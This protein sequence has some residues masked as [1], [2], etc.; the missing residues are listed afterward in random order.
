L[1]KFL[2]PELVRL[3][4]SDGC[5]LLIKKRLTAGE[6]RA[7]FALMVKSMKMGE[8][9]EIDP[10]KVQ[11]ATV[12]AYLVDWNL[13]DAEGKPVVIKGAPSSVVMNALDNLD[14]DGYTEIER[15]I[16]EHVVA[17]EEEKK[18]PA[19]ENASPATSDSVG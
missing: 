17:L 1:P 19:P 13:S 7:M 14:V 15:A 2:K 16:S 11:L 8:A 10:V 9:T 5:W 3:E 4:L 18:L 12:V 6:R